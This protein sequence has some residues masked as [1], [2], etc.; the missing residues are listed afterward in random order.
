MV[1]SAYREAAGYFE[2]ALS[3]LRASA[4][5]SVTH[6]SRPSTCG[7]PCVGHSAVLGDL[8][9]VLGVPARGRGPRDGPR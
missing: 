2:Q 3:A 6:A 7:S 4:A 5:G 1:R 8:E 9:R